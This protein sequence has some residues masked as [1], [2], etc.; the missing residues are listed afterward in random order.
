MRL[1]AEMPKKKS[2]ANSKFADLI[3]LADEGNGG[4]EEVDEEVNTSAESPKSTYDEDDA[5]SCSS[6]DSLNTGD[7]LN[8]KNSSDEMSSQ[9]DSNLMMLDDKE[10]QLDELKDLIKK[11]SNSTLI[12]RTQLK[13]LIH[14]LYNLND[15]SQ[16]LQDNSVITTEAKILVESVMEKVRCL[17]NS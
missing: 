13:S 15:C 2:T 10:E 16:Q 8:M 11:D 1:S 4:D 6:I 9:V 7:T 3:D 17:T 12:K 14:E 5:N